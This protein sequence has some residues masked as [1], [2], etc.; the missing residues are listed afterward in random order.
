MIMDPR[1]ASCFARRL[2]AG[3]PRGAFSCPDCGGRGVNDCPHE[4]HVDDLLADLNFQIELLERCKFGLAVRAGGLFHIV[5]LCHDA[6]GE[7]NA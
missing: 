2:N 1:P 4:E 6:F 7:G 5:P 3:K